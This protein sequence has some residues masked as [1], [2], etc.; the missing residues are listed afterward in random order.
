[1]KANIDVKPFEG[2][3]GGIVSWAKQIPLV[4]PKGSETGHDTKAMPEIWS[5]GAGFVKD[6]NAR[7][8]LPR[9][10]RCSPR[11]TTHRGLPISSKSSTAPAS[12]VTA[13]T[14]CARRTERTGAGQAKLTSSADDHDGSTEYGKASHRLTM[15]RRASQ[16]G[17]RL[18]PVIIGR[19]RSCRFSTA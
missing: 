17:S 16:T 9:S 4:F 13:A 1:M 6:A 7:P 11:P 12:R 2:A 5:D 15:S 18:R 14:A 8:P 3:A 19:T 10:W